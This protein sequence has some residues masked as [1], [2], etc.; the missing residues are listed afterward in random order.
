MT[1]SSGFVAERIEDGERG[2]SDAARTV[3]FH[4][5]VDVVQARP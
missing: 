5:S 3:V 4:V 1:L 2:G